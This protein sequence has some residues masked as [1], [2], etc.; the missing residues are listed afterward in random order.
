MYVRI[1]KSSEYHTVGGCSEDLLYKLNCGIW[2]D[3]ELPPY[4]FSAP[5]GFNTNNY[6]YRSNNKL[7]QKTFP[8]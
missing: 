3:L 2:I 7:I 4:F 6:F 1:E 8:Q 5:E